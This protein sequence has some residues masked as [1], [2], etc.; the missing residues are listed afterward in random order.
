M[1]KEIGDNYSKVYEVYFADT[2]EIKPL[3]DSLA[4]LETK[5]LAKEENYQR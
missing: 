1:E 5:L 3:R 2:L 4:N